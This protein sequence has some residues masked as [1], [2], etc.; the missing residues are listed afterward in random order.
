VPIHDSGQVDF[1]VFNNIAHLQK[2][3]IFFI[4]AP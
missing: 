2:L 1:K 3:D 4:P